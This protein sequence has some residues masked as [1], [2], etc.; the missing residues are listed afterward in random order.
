LNDNNQINKT[1]V[2]RLGEFGLIDHLTH[3][4]NSIQPSTLKAV[5]DDAAVIEVAD[6]QCVVISTD[7]L[8][9][10]IH[11]DLMYTPLRHLG[12]KA[13]IVNLSD[14]C[15]MNVIPTQITVSIA[16]SSKYTVEALEELYAGIKKAC[17][18]YKVDLVGGDTTSSPKG[19][20]ISV[21][22]M[23]MAPK[24]QIVY[25]NGAKAGDIVCL[26]GNI[27][28]AYLGLQILEREKQVYQS[29]P[30]VQP[31]LEEHRY[32]I[33]RLLKPEARKD[34]VLYFL[35]NGIKPGS[36]IDVSDGLASELFHICKQSATG[37][38]IEEANVP[39]HP[40]AEKLS[41]DFN[42]D[43]ITCALHG[44]EDYELLFTI[45]PKDLDKIRVMPDVY[46]IGEIMAPESGIKLLSTGN[47]LHTIKAQGWVHF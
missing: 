13:V 1:N 36:M 5:G 41:I 8:V 22:A 28:A 21:T 10:N 32:L 15:A 6:G 25:R 46:I 47:Q 30:T 35:N 2:N 24:D 44:G 39:I 31:Q 29:A 45:D 20:T 33:E 7:M 27:G 3:S 4:F 38:L 9:E 43:P 37:V 34:A 16:I 42:I 18:L 26:T 23:G 40:D 17:E 11:F 19:M 12:Y 14:I